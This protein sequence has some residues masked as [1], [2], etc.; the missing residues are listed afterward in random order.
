MIKPTLFVGLGTT[1]TN[2]LKTLRLLMSEE[3]RDSGLPI[4]RYVSIETREA[5]T[6]DNPRQFKDYE[7]ISVVNATIEDT[8]P[9]QRKLDSDQPG[10]VYNPHLKDWLNPLLLNQIQ[11]FKDG[12]G[13][14][15][16]AGRLCLWENW[17][18]IRRILSSARNDIIDH[19]NIQRTQEILTKHYE[20]KDLDVPNQLVDQDGINAYIVG[21]LCGGSC[22][23]MF[24]D[25]AYFIGNL[26]GGNNANNVYGVFTMFDRISAGAIQKILPFVRQIA[27]PVSL[28]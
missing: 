4:F 6:G 25:M 18:E 22:S 3:Y 13:N 28:N 11:S 21:T 16:M 10:S 17:E 5:E 23:G 15:R 8:V 14:I 19:A 1:G 27:L 24:I 20:A 12:A 2:I 26:L 7:Q 9:I